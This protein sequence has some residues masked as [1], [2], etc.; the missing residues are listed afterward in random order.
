V[1]FSIKGE[2]NTVI[3]RIIDGPEGHHVIQNKSDT[4]RQIS[5]TF[6][7]VKLKR[8]KD[9]LHVQERLVGTKKGF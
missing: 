1:L 9:D 7:H 2:G 8:L 3:F 6:S 5:H 4:E